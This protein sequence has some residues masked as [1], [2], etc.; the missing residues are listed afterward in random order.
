MK[1]SIFI[2]LALIMVASL[3]LSACGG[4]K[5]IEG[6]G[7]TYYGTT[8]TDIPTMDPQV[9]EDEVSI[10]YIENT[11]M[12]LTNY[13][14]VTSEVVPEMATSWTVSDD[15][16]EYTF[17]IRTDV[18]WVKYDQETG[19]VAIVELDGEAQYVDAYDFEAAALRAC[20]PN[21]GGYYSSVL[22]GVLAG[23]ADVLYAEDPANIPAE[24]W[25]A[26]GVEAVDAETVVYTLS[27]PASFFVSM[28]PMWMM[29][30]VPTW[31]IDE[32][33][34]EWTE[35]ANIVTNGRYV[36]TDWTHDVSRKLM[37]NPFMPE[38]LYG[39]GNIE[40]FEINVVDDTT[41][42]YAL[43]L[44]NEIEE[45]GIPSA[46]LE[47]H[48]EAYPEET[49]FVQ[50]MSVFYIAFRMTKAP[51]DQAEV[52]R[53]FAAAFDSQTYIDTVRQGQG[54]VMTHF[55]PPGIF[56]APPVD[57]VGVGFD[58]EFAAE[59][60]AAAGYPNCEDLPAVTLLGYSGES[61][62][63]WL[64]FAQASWEEY[65]GCSA[66][67]IILEQQSFADLLSATTAPDEEAPHMWT[68]GW[69]P[70]YGDENNWVG[71][72]LHCDFTTRIKRTCN[73]IDAKIEA[74]RTEQDQA[75][76]KQ[77][78]YEIEDAFFGYDGEMPFFPIFR[79]MG[80][81]AEHAWLDHI[82]A[83]FGGDQYYTWTIDADMR[84]AAQGE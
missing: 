72:V 53:A 57:E 12:H 78:Y 54:Q 39:S 43:W 69:G 11:F 65:L 40:F 35:A 13:D 6:S 80:Y 81:S 51:F 1:K 58:P 76:R 71:D 52:R 5:A 23:C 27:A 36:M 46:E 68:L 50:E 17:T 33:G 42:S 62:L 60:L 16:L 74:A 3:I 64:E 41:T 49:A 25:D 31:V 10:N 70:D 56:G 34:A 77:M 18:P 4:P 9:A 75:V 37:R 48:L 20:D 38:D 83:N 15:G 66:D 2:A 22:A 26:I 59:Q 24:A 63:N 29:A 8:T 82:L 14:L 44:N 47:A 84:A 79:N 32:F 28:T 73:D 45:S 55:A 30:P 7:I 21:V 61:T 67:Q 19:E